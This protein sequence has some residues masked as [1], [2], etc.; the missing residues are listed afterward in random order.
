[1]SVPPEPDWLS[2]EFL[3][4]PYP[5]YRALRESDPVHYDPLRKRWLLT[6]YDDVT[7]VLRDDVAFTAQEHDTA[8][9]MLVTDP[10]Q[11]TRLRSLV[12]KAFTPR[13]VLAL[14]P[15]I[16]E[17][18]DEL[19]AAVAAH[20]RMDVIAQYAF[21]LPITV[22]A[23]LLGVDPDRRDFFRDASSKIAVAMGPSTDTYMA[24]NAFAG[25][26]Q[27]IGY[28]NELIEA[29]TA[30]PRDD[31]VSSLVAVEDDGSTLAR[32]ELLAML[33][34]LLVGGHET[35]VNL[36]ANGLLALLRDRE[37]FEQLRTT[38]G[39][40][41]PAVEEMLRYDAPVQ[42]SGR[43]ARADTSIGGVAIRKGDHVRVLLAAA[44]RDPAM[45]PRPDDL[46]L[47]REMNA[48]VAFGTGIHHCLGAPL[49]RLEG[50]IALAALVRRFP[51]MRLDETRPLRY[52]PAAVLRGMEALHVRL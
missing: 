38:P 27:L 9:T 23:E 34:I 30:E 17:I 42:Y 13:A 37:K 46:E 39:I 2:Q 19:L 5:Y 31:L 50:E 18:V 8:T 28:F 51:E 35:T 48:H 29:R 43:I 52:R 10:P 44:N 25:R 47:E 36:I 11:H 20:G 24:Q 1:M 4:D 49:A 32:G 45:F 15:R 14:T 7:K 33:L 40:E 26:G 21:P 16:H 22:I 12:S 41:R 3:G 6:R